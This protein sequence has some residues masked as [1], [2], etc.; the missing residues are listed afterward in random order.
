MHI[1]TLKRAVKY[2][3]KF[4]K[5]LKFGAKTALWTYLFDVQPTL[6]ISNKKIQA[7]TDFAEK[8]FKQVIEKYK[9]DQDKI[10]L[11]DYSGKIPVWIFWFQGKESRPEL[12]KIC[13]DSVEKFL[14][15]DIAEIHYLSEENYLDY[16]DIPE[17]IIEKHKKGKMCTAH[18]SDV[19][20]VSL[21]AKYG[22]MWLDSTILVTEVITNKI[23]S[24]DLY[25][26]RIFD[27]NLYPKEPSR[28]I[29]NAFLWV[30]KPNNIFFCFL[31]DCLLSY[32][33]KHNQMVDYI[34][35]D[36]IILIA[37]KHFSY[38][39]ELMD[40]IEPNIK[41]MNLTYSS[42]NLEF[43]KEKWQEIIDN[44]SFHKLTYKYPLVDFTDDNKLTIYGYIKSIF[45]T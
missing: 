3:S 10:K 34:L 35:L 32:W 25:T 27:E 18:F 44:A 40:K 38:V 43:T 14:P 21:L 33:A 17:Y 15:N 36:Y 9:A 12:V 45:N 5:N 24:S 30:S 41:D 6:N 2:Q 7:L 29:W 37:L 1:T 42:L 28:A 20:R 19:I 23:L 11:Q 16:V 22:G 26:L 39:K 31:R 4:W 13:N 8:E